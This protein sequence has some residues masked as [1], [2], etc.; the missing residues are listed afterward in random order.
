MKDLQEIAGVWLF[1]SL[2]SEAFEACDSGG[3]LKHA[4]Q[5]HE[6]ET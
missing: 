2:H 6:N 1:L 3:R 5:I 4:M